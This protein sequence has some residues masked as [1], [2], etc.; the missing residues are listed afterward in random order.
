MFPILIFEF[1]RIC[2]Q[3]L[4][5]AMFILLPFC[6]YLI[7]IQALPDDDVLKGL[8][9]KQNYMISMALYSAMSFVLIL[10]PQ[11][12][13]FERQLEWIKR[14]VNTRVSYNTYFLSKSLKTHSLSIIGASV[15]LVTG[16]LNGVSLSL[17]Q[18]VGL[19]FIIN[20]V[21]ITLYPF[22]YILSL[23]E[24]VSKVVA[25]SNCLYFILAFLGGLWIPLDRFPNLLRMLSEWVPTTHMRHVVIYYINHGGILWLSMLKLFIFSI[26]M[27][28]L[29]IICRHNWRDDIDI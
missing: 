28:I 21:L 25:L 26:I 1:Q 3:K 22:A 23:I 20:L 10:F 4:M 11:E 5:L 24:D 7:S 29:I 18:W 15:L 13:A 8:V 19:F 6:F 14:F 2:R 27:I 12:L 16:T 17:Q 9:F